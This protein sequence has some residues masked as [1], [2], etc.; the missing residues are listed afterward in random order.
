M[1][2]IPKKVAERYVNTIKRFQPIIQSAKTRDVN[3]S[4]TVIII[5]DMLAEVFGYDKYS[6]ITSEFSIRGT[7]CDLA[8]K[9][10]GKLQFLIEVKAINLELKDS[11]VKQAVD[12]AANQGIEWVILT[13]GC[14]W[15]IY[16]ITFTKP[17]DQELV[18]EF[19]FTTLNPKQQA[20]LEYLFFISKEGWV[21]SSI[22]GYH[23]Q[24]Q[25]LN[26]FFIAAIIQSNPIIDTVRKEARKIVPDIKIDSEG[27]KEVIENEVLKREVVEGE[28]AEEAKKRIAKTYVKIT[29]AKIKSANSEKHVEE[30]E[31]EAGSEAEESKTE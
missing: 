18:L 4:D 13:N 20:H 27:L 15:R 21:K 7:Y 2:V 29:R 31:P 14:T 8:T 10:D 23:E 22:E 16:K 30:S 1:I 28:K 3:E 26:K 12:Y 6:E 5:T 11:F 9:I 19:D 25:V 24:K 17:I